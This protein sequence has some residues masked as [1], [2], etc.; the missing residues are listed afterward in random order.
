MSFQVSTSRQ[1]E[2][3]DIT[4]EVASQVKQS[5]VEE[6]IALVYVPHAT[7]ALIVNENERGLVS[8]MLGIIKELVPRDK[9]FEHDRIDN[10]AAAHLTSALL[11]P[12]LT[13]PVTGGSIERGT[14]QNIFLVELDGPR[15]RKVIV[16]VIGK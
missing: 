11:K 15:Q 7:A 1:I 2:L 6:G 8:D 13:L 16:K 9:Q 10:N 12:D 14:W 4:R 5:G 3:I